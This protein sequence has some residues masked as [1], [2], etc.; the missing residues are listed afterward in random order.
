MLKCN[1][2]SNWLKLNCL[3]VKFHSA[4]LQFTFMLKVNYPQI[5]FSCIWGGEPWK[6]VREAKERIVNSA[7][8]WRP[9]W[10][11]GWT[12]SA[13]TCHMLDNWVKSAE[14]SVLSTEW[15]YYDNPAVK[16]PST[17]TFLWQSLW[18]C[19]RM[20]WQHRSPRWMPV[21]LSLMQTHALRS[22]LRMKTVRTGMSTPQSHLQNKICEIP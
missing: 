9:V 3:E 7:F 16:P 14:D 1:C 10:E 8:L 22:S 21:S 15:H 13:A 12:V 17:L 18:I 11:M 5:C 6:P 2:G 19:L 4:F 20:L